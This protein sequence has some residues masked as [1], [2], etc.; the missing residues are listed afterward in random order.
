MKAYN[1]S[2]INSAMT[3]LGEMMDYGVNNCGIEPSKF[4]ETFIGLGY[5]TAFE[6]GNPKYVVGMSGNELAQRVIDEGKLTTNPFSNK[7]YPCIYWCGWI[8]AYY[9]WNTAMPFRDIIACLGWDYLMKSYPALHTASED[10]AVSTFSKIIKKAQK[11]TRIQ[12][13][14]LNYG[15]SQS[16]LAKASEINLRT[17]QEYENKRRDI[18]RASGDV[19][20]RLSRALSCSIE[21]IMEYEI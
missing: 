14:R 16:Q 12:A 10:K 7:E 18:N 21:D 2:Y 20:R 17:L 5:A 15:Y 13:A 19:L 9:Q 6:S 11:T 4:F 1:S 3:C 8:L